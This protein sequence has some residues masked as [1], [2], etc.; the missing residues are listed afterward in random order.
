MKRPVTLFHP[1]PLRWQ[2]ALL[3]SALVLVSNL[4]TVSRTAAA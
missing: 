2:V 3:A 1:L 4:A